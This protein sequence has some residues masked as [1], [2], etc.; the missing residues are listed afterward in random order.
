MTVISILEEEEKIIKA[1]KKGSLKV[2]TRSEHNEMLEVS[3]A[4]NG[5]VRDRDYE[6]DG[7]KVDFIL[8]EYPELQFWRR[9]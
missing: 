3:R 5:L 7:E 2:V 6:T 8:A 9:T 1:G 4:L